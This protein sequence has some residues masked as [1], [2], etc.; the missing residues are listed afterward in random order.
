MTELAEQ[1]TVTLVPQ[2]VKADA[3]LSAVVLHNGS[4]VM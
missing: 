1:T 4:H 2:V 3:L